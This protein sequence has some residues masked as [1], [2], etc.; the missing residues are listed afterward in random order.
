MTEISTWVS[1]ESTD[2]ELHWAEFERHGV[3]YTF[4]EV[5]ERQAVL[6]A[7]SRFKQLIEQE[8]DT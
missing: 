6:A 3:R 5:T 1:D 8:V 4:V 2:S 7:E